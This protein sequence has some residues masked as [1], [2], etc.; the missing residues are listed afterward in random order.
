MANYKEP[1]NKGTGASLEVK[2]ARR[3]SYYQKNRDKIIKKSSNRYK[4]NKSTIKD[5]LRWHLIKAKYGL[6]KSQYESMEINQNYK[7][8]IC[9]NKKCVVVDHCH[10]SGRVRGLLCHGCN[11]DMH[12]I[13]NPI[14]LA[15]ALRYKC[16]S[17]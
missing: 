5:Y 15:S 16:E 13:D 2:R 6:T 3:A 1:W 10:S 11:R 17:E 7:C 12:I 9:K 8:A 4:N 14:L